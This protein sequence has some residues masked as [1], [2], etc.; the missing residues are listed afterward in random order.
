MPILRFQY[1]PKRLFFRFLTQQLLGILPVFLLSIFLLK[2]YLAHSLGG[3]E[4]A[5]AFLSSLNR[6]LWLLFL[7]ISSLI[8]GITLVSG[9]R[10]VLPLGRILVKARSIQRRD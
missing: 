6:A 5:A 9:F 8:I 1:F 10:F 3:M 4:N 2:A 7:V